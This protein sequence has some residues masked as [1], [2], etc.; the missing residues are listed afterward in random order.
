MGVPIGL[1]M[2][3]QSHFTTTPAY[4][5][6]RTRNHLFKMRHVPSTPTSYMIYSQ[7]TYSSLLFFTSVFI[8]GKPSTSFI[9]I[10]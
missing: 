10:Q 4:K 8:Q 3:E 9:F 1:L 7:N 6:V 5:L 2:G